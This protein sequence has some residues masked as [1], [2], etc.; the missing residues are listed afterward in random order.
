MIK[1][2]DN[3]EI[4]YT[5][6]DKDY[7]D[8]FIEYL[9]SK[10]KE[11]LN[12]FNID[13]LERRVHIK[14][15]DNL[16]EYRKFRNDMLK[17]YNRKVADWEVGCASTYNSMN[18]IDI[19]S[20]SESLKAKGHAYDKI[21]TIIKVGVHEFTH[22]CFSQFRNN[23]KTLLWLNEGFATYFAEQYDIKKIKIECTLD[24]LL[25]KTVNYSNYYAL[26]YY[27][28][29][30]YD[31]NYILKLASNIDLLKEETPKIYEKTK[32]L[33]YTRGITK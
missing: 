8:K 11:I 20:Y 24:E 13:K 33:Y 15:W 12:F 30:N 9:L 4:E 6:M 14:F 7:I 3:L 17:Q 19:V 1:K 23:N 32:E 31:R 21:S 2:F 26:T 10:E 28:F 22:V 16:E 18:M 5:D 27:L 29:D 25:S